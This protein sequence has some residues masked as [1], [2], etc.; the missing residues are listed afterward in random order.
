MIQKIMGAE[1][2]I[3][4]MTFLAGLA[5]AVL[6]SDIEFICVSFMMDIR[7]KDL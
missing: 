3:V 7:T 6:C 1:T 5:L 2:A 4:T